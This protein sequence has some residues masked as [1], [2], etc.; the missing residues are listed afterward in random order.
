MAPF[1]SMSGEN[2]YVRKRPLAKLKRS[3]SYVL[4]Y[5]S[6]QI[7]ALS[8]VLCNHVTYHAANVMIKWRKPRLQSLYEYIKLIICLQ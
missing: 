8:R 3:L 2:R 7:A 5:V 6:V 1:D 4:S